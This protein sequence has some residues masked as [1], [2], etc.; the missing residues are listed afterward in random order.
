MG[1]YAQSAL[2]KKYITEA[3]LDERLSY[4]FRVRMRCPATHV[5]CLT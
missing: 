3:D 4:M 1:K 5:N 2:D